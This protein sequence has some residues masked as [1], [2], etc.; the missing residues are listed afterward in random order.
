[1][2]LPSPSTQPLSA[3]PGLPSLAEQER[4]FKEEVH[5]HDS[6]L[7]SYLRG[8]FPSIRDVE[9]VTQES[10]LRVWKACATQ[11]IRSAKGFVFQ[12]A[13]HVAT[14]TVRHELASPISEVT[15]LAI[16]PVCDDK[17]DAAEAACTREEIMLLA[18]AIDALPRRCREIFILRKI[19]RLPQ[20]EIARLLGL[21]EQTVQVQ[22]QRGM[23]CCEKFFTRRGV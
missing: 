18:D 17:P 22:V 23:K 20:K 21:S 11:S 4:W 2:N 10:Y 12:I 16:L 5:A 9:D 8:S 6:E 19:K 13:R 1:M 15:D 7:K 14:D 3:P